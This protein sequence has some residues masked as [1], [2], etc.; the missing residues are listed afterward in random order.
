[1]SGAMPKPIPLDVRVT[2]LEADNAEIK[3]RVAEL[4]A[5]ERQFYKFVIEV[6]R[7]LRAGDER[8]AMLE[9]QDRGP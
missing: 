5:A 1:M 6:S 2:D 9:R 8:L 7:R 4:E 3:R